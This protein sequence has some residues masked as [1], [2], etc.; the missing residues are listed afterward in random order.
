MPDVFF[1]ESNGREIKSAIK[2]P[3]IPLYVSGKGSGSEA[4]LHAP[5]VPFGPLKR[6]FVAS[7]LLK[8][9]S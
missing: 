5:S 8:M 4:C 3:D 1:V 9:G 7:L 6:D 2:T